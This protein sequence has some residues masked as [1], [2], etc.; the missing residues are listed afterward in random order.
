MK[1][2]GFLAVAVA[3]VCL[4]TFIG[5]K[6]DE[7]TP[8]I[9]PQVVSNV[10]LNLSDS[11][12]TKVLSSRFLNMLNHNFVYGED[13]L[14]ADTILNLSI[15]AQRDKADENGEFIEENIVT[16]FVFDMYGIEII[17][18]TEFSAGYPQKEGHLYLVPQGFTV[19]KHQNAEITENEDGTYT[20]TTQVSVDGHD[21]EDEVLYA[22]SLFT[23]N[24]KSA[25][26]FNIIYSE[27]CETSNNSLQV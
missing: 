19:Y 18:T 7:K 11:D 23:K 10:T 24:S 12:S 21:G 4:L 15:I 1:L 25:L 13:F 16:S 2:K 26:G 20:V 9:E 8:E 3:V 27:I 14:S 6:S 22:K 5:L 17:D